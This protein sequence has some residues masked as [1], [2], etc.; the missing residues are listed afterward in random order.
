MCAMIQIRNVPDELHERLRVRAA[1]EG[2]SLSALLLREAE[3][4]A[5]RPSR[6]ELLA[7][8]ARRPALV[9][10]TSSREH[11]RSLRDES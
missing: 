4:V 6:R 7:R 2:L 10:A 5:E 1:E 8:A 11:I 3:R 9:P